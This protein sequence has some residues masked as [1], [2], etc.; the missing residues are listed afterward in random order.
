MEGVERV[1][2]HYL[3]LNSKTL[4][5]DYII[6]K[7]WEEVRAQTAELDPAGELIFTTHNKNDYC[8]LE[9]SKFIFDI[10]I[11]KADGSRYINTSEIGLVNNAV[12]YMFK[13]AKLRFGSHDIEM[14]DHL[15]YA[16]SCLGHLSYGSAYSMNNG[17]KQG[18]FYENSSDG[19]TTHDGFKKIQRLLLKDTTEKGQ[20]TFTVPFNHIF[21]FKGKVL[22]G[23][24]LIATFTKHI[25]DLP[26]IRIA[27]VDAAKIHLKRMV[28]KIPY[29]HPS[30]LA[31]TELG[32]NIIAEKHID[33]PFLHRE[34]H[35]VAVPSQATS[36]D[37]AIMHM[38]TKSKPMG[39]I[40]WFQTGKMEDQTKNPNMLNHC[41]LKDARVRMNTEIYPNLDL[42]CD[43]DNN[44]YM[45]CYDRFDDFRK[46]LT[47]TDTPILPYDFK[48]MYP[49]FAFDLSNQRERI[50]GSTDQITVEFKFKRNVP[51]DTYA[52]SLLLYDRTINLQMLNDKSMKVVSY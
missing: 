12:M 15:G 18:W 29:L 26:I 2:P 39:L 7:K 41:D 49:Y 25:T 34:C 47:F 46:K 13:S 19:I 27:G 35:S 14:V 44:T 37:Y 11:T 38:D 28:W 50:V 3:E 45:E 40:V 9:E 4:I 48:N 1:K 22:I 32:R 33:Y 23:M 16:T 5:D 8:L 52:Y 17:L 42:R 30:I 43:F 24:D 51:A 21:G 10:D 31:E 20:V 36:F 6:S